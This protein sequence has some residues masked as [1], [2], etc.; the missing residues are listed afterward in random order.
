MA[1]GLRCFPAGW[2]PSLAGCFPVFHLVGQVTTRG[3]GK[4]A[5]ALDEAKKARALFRKHGLRHDEG[6]RG[7]GA[8]KCGRAQV[9]G[10]IALCRERGWDQTEGSHPLVMFD[11]EAF[12]SHEPL[13]HV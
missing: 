6:G 9:S 5:K 12:P 3:T 8:S 2:R 13:S 11:T 1:E 4:S 7:D 10:V